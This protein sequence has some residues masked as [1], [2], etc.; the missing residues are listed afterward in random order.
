M[1]LLSSSAFAADSSDVQ[2]IYIR[3]ND[4]ENYSRVVFDWG[5]SKDGKKSQKL[6]PPNYTTKKN[7]NSLII[8]FTS[9]VQLT[10]EGATPETLSRVTG[11]KIIS[12]N[13]VEIDF[14]EGL[15]V[16]NF[17]TDNRLVI[18]IK[19]KASKKNTAKNET[20][21]VNLAANIE[22]AAGEVEKAPEKKADPNPEKELL[23]NEISPSV[24]VDEIN[25]PKDVVN[26]ISAEK[27]Y[28]IVLTSTSSIP[29]AAFERNGYLWV[30]QGK[31]NI[32]IPPQISGGDAAT[33]ADHFESVPAEGGLSVF[34][35][36]V[37]N[38]LEKIASG[39]GLAWKI[40]ISDKS[41][42]SKPIEYKK[43]SEQVGNEV[44][45]SL[46]WPALS[47]RRVAEFKDPDTGDKVLLALV[48]S[49]KDFTG[50][51]QGFVDFESLPS[52]I[53]LAVIPK[54]DDL[55]LS[56]T[57]ESIK[58]TSASGLNIASDQDELTS[59]G[60]SPKEDVLSKPVSEITSIYDFKNW[61]IGTKS[62]LSDNQRLI[63]SGLGNQTEAKKAESLIN[64]A[65]LVLSFNYAPEAIGY[66]E[67][68][69]S[70]VPEIDTNPEFMA[71]MAAAEAL[72]WKPK[73][74]FVKFS[75]ASLNDVDE[76]KYWRAY[77][78]ARLDD[79][80]QAAKILPNNMDVLT[81]YTDDIKI[82]LSLVLFEVALREG[83]IAKS[84]SIMDILEPLRAGMGTAH[85]SAYDYLLG[86]FDRQTNKAKEATDLWKT[87]STGPDDL[88]RAKARF[89]S[90][91]MQLNSK[92]ITQDK[93]IDS[94]EGL[95]YAWRG[96]DL[97]VAINTNLADI[98]LAKGENVKALTLMEM[99]HSLN[100]KSELGKKIDADMRTVFKGLFS[101]KKIKDISPVDIL[102]LYNEFSNLIPAGAEGDALTRQL[103][104]RMAIAD[105]LPRAIAILKKQVDAGLSGEEGATVAIRLATLQNLD[106]KPDDALLS[107]DKA[108][109]L[110][111]GLPAEDVLTKQNDI[112]LLRAKAYSLKGKP[113]DAF[114]ALALLQQDE[115]SLHLRADIAWRGKKW[116]DA[117]DSLEQLVQ[118][119]NIDL[120]KP[121]SDDDAELLLNWGVALYL[122]DN[123]YVLAN[124]RERYSDAMLATTRAQK[125]DVVTRPRQ[126]SLL[127]DRETIN[128]I[129][130]E[131]VIFKDFLKSFRSADPTSKPK[132]VSPQTNDNVIN[133]NPA[134]VPEELKNAPDLKTDE[135]LGD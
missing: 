47:A 95:R 23:K 107:L 51:E 55:K 39:G 22:A 128:S 27:K 2:K 42:P 90:T 98:Y 67:L 38:K 112:G 130:D 8:T 19:G 33:S 89:A 92:E 32:K 5:N 109:T 29:L 114:A 96:D 102:I 37:N 126:G 4:K 62:D 84:K 116:Q 66:L 6:Q 10:S 127:A 36:K 110:L 124:L 48:E 83:N 117:A 9:G 106:S 133:P 30:V 28:T 94:L 72:S 18:D 100:P 34:R 21:P 132:L 80:Q 77:T 57:K 108:E 99:A 68:A 3:G 11:Y 115:D 75:N 17:V 104:E 59:K 88:Y 54:I 20:A 120:T 103:A 78:L 86:E 49:A 41:Q 97:E 31:E 26:P 101:D 64:L 24:V 105:L 74:A 121:L 15:D 113:D 16:R 135:V 87:L 60:E 118:N 111:K 44:K 45:K 71:L 63:M 56:S 70:V 40:D 81:T 65:K 25:P 52:L 35:L 76:M 13:Q 119:R 58:I 43:I 91:M 7:T 50:R 69:Q 85:A 125:F 46:M 73:E 129:I 134:N 131:T 82:P 93:A 61:Q 1:A 53:G 79:W 123:R 14:D 12:P 122:A